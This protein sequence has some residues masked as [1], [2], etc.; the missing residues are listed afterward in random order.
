MLILKICL[1]YICK[2]TEMKT[3][4]NRTATI[5]NNDEIIPKVSIMSQSEPSKIKP[6]FNVQNYGKQDSFLLL[7]F[8]ESKN[9]SNWK[10]FYLQK[11][12]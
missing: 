3:T 7:I 11:V 6:H 5:F 4:S 12:V 9:I 8:F 10:T 2:I 1:F